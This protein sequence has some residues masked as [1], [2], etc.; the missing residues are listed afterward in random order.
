[1]TVL[2]YSKAGTGKSDWI[3]YDVWVCPVCGRTLSAPKTRAYELNLD[4]THRLDEVNVRLV[5]PKESAQENILKYNNTIHVEMQKVYAE[6][7]F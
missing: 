4:C 6:E 1:M 7:E 5:F 3:M 2:V